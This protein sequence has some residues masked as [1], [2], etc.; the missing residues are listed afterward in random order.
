MDWREYWN[1]PH[2]IYANERHRTLH[3]DLIARDIARLVPSRD[4]HVLD[5]GCGEADTA[6][7]LAAKCGKLYL[8]DTAETVRARLQQK[9]AGDSKIVV[10]DEAAL[11]GVADESL[12]FII[13]NSVL[14]YLT[15]TELVAILDF[16]REKLKSGGTLAL[17]DVIPDDANAVA[18]TKALL[19]F[20]FHGGFLTAAFKSLV[21]TAL[22]DYRKLRE[23]LG[24]TRYSE[25]QMLSLLTQNGFTAHRAENN[26]GHNQG[27]MLFLASPLA[28]DA[29]SV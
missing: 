9:H 17:G 1:G 22:S 23:T 21:K 19:S 28:S 26:I 7:A 20:A 24:L 11:E 18:D 8:F 27:R 29:T 4:A 2:S 13:V 3:F 14:Q 10:L 12:D 6:T 15:E 16:A 5:Y 25:A